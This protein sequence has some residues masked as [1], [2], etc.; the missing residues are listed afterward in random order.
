MYQ[1]VQQLLDHDEGHDD[2][3]SPIVDIDALVT[4]EFHHL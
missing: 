3:L 1:N 4:Q 2:S